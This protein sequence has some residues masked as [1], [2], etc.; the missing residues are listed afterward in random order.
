MA[1]QGYIDFIV[2]GKINDVPIT[3]ASV[4]L[5]LLKSFSEDVAAI[6]NSID[7]LDKGNVI[8]SIGEGS[9][10]YKT[11]VALLAVNS[12]AVDAKTLNQ[13]NDLSSINSVRSKIIEKWEKK[14]K[15][16]PTIE[17]EIRPNGEDGIKITS[18]KQFKK[19]ESVWIQSEVYLYGV[20]K[21]IGGEKPNIHLTTGKNEKVLISCKEGDI[22]N[23]TENR[24]YHAGGVRV[25][26]KQNLY[27]GE[28][29]EANLIEFVNYS[30]Q[31][32]EDE[33]LRL[34]AKGRE[35]WTDIPDHVEWVR[36]L[37]NDG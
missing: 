23:Q 12:L 1:A 24:V 16:N 27:T 2:R 7:G 28:I 35:A 9:L 8:V 22:K 36:N 37:R 17:F 3:P 31:Y 19:E 25:F 10:K 4:E 5:G 30:P 14:T 21:D 15:T 13:T 34:T 18:Q 6:M 20:F 32:D 26:A 29:K 33:L 11:M